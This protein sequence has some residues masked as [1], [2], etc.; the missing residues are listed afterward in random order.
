[1]N[2]P[3][4]TYAAID[5][6]ILSLDV[7]KLKGIIKEEDL[8]RRA[9]TVYSAVRPLLYAVS[10]FSLLPRHWRDAVTLFVTTLD[11]LVVL[12]PT[13]KMGKDL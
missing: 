4:M 10:A 1:M 3:R 12:D 6:R 7:P 2:T 5:E 8:V 11:H 13:F 9:L